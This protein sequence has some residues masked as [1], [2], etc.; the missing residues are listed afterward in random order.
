VTPA[1]G[2]DGRLYG[3]DGCG[4]IMSGFIFATTTAGSLTDLHDFDPA[5]GFCPNAGLT[6]ATDGSFYGT[7]LGGGNNQ[8]G[9]LFK[10]TPKGTYTVLHFFAGGADGSGPSAAPIEASNG[11]LY[12]TTEGDSTGSTI[13][14]YT[15][16]GGLNTI[17][18]FDGTHGQGVI[19][20]LI[21]GTDGK[22]Y[23]TASSGGA[24][25]CGT[26][27]QM[28]TVGK[29]LKSYSF[30][31]G[32][33]GAQPVGPLVQAADGNFYGTT[34][35]GGGGGG[36]VFKMGSDVRPSVLYSFG[37]AGPDDGQEPL[38]GLIQATEGNLYGT[39]L[40]GGSAGFGTLFQISTSGAYQLL[41]SFT[42]PIGESPFAGLLQH[43]N[44]L[45]YGT[46]TTSGANGFGALYSLD[47]GLGPFIT[48]VQSTGKV[49]RATQILGQGLTGT[50]GVTFNA[51]AATSFKVL[52]DT[53]L[54]AVV[55][56][57]ATTGP[58]VVTTPSGTLTSNK[59]FVVK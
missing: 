15:A 9:V 55:P 20:P 57:G 36:T 42:A 26:V 50:T 3:T 31:C 19:A 4:G 11:A 34:Q 56:S 32:L 41:F 2:R 33:S 51:V 40:Q 24:N 45:L 5:E 38:A 59:N 6:L 30:L 48:F 47:M 52:A 44:G 58:V 46:T 18:Q 14:K 17:Y 10:I 22:L 27:F 1:Q 53:Y 54:V 29:L 25:G 49:G 21:Q 28:S 23:G 7:T 13:Y 12:G 35:A 8:N 39:T 43:T 16:A 37:A